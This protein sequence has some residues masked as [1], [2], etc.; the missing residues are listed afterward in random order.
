MGAIM[1][2]KTLGGLKNLPTNVKHT[3]TKT[4]SSFAVAFLWEN[5]LYFH[6][7]VLLTGQNNRGKGRF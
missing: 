5:V 2:S 7:L 4:A 3:P 6:L 1:D